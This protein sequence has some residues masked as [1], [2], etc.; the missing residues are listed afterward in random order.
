[1]TNQG[2]NPPGP[3]EL[4]ETWRQVAADAEQRWNDY[5][6]QLMG[7]EAFGQMLARS[8]DSYLTM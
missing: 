4:M 1:M 8:M 2:S 7:T 3:N 5:F 6:N